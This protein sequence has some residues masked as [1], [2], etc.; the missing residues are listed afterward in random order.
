MEP[1]CHY[2]YHNNNESEVD[3]ICRR[4]FQNKFFHEKGW[5]LDDD[6]YM[7][8]SRVTISK[9]MNE[10]NQNNQHTQHNPPNQQNPHNQRN[11]QNQYTHRPKLA[12]YREAR[13]C[14]AYI[15]KGPESSP[16]YF[17]FYL[18]SHEV[19]IKRKQFAYFV[20]LNRDTAEKKG[21][22]K[23]ILRYLKFWEEKRVQ[24]AAY[25]ES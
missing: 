19:Y 17:S 14:S 9:I 7:H 15:Q 16:M 1:F 25:I 11:Q 3:S 21:Q 18:I 13:R 2:R 8:C 23:K 6:G 22:M 10:H 12:Y 24:V 20:L 4:A 5:A